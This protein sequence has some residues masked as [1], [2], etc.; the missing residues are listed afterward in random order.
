MRKRLYISSGNACARCHASLI[1]SEE[2]G[3]EVPVENIAHI[4]GVMPRSPRY[5]VNQTP[6]ERNAFE[7][8]LVVCGRCHPLIDGDASTFTVDRLRAMKIEHEQL[9]RMNWKRAATELTAAELDHVVKFLISQPP[10]PS[11]PSF[12]LVPVEKKIRRNELSDQAAALIKIGL[13][14]R[15]LVDRFLKRHPDP[16][17]PDRLKNW[18][19]ARYEELRS[20]RTDSDEIFS[21]LL[22]RS[23]AGFT[24]L[25]QQMAGLAVLVYFFE[26][27]EIFER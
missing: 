25:R 27:C 2:G 12:A 10:P 9:V 17:Y 8:L 19:V 18:F 4:K 15:R 21:D 3:R 22:A 24:T 5:D 6:E 20:Q 14:Q 26:L 11:M 13:A 1:E 7:N 16:T 23:T